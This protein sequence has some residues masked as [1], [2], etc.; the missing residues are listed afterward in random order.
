MA[1]LATFY[2]R[3]NHVTDRRCLS[4]Q[5]LYIKAPLIC[6]S[7]GFYD[8]FFGPGTGSFLI[9]AFNQILRMNFVQATATAKLFNI[10][11][12]IGALAIFIWE[13]KVIYLLGLPLAF[14][15]VL[16]NFFGSRL[17]LRK[18]ERVVRAFL[19]ISLA[20][21]FVSLLCKYFF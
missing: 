7:L 10:T 18:G 15:N 3:K 21:L 5:D 20:I 14:T 13:K 1:I 2:P 16:G 17:V 4:A 12:N 19:M 9:I 8:G 6:L 11:S